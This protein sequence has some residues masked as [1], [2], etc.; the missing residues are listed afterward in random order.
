[1][2]DVNI[3]TFEEDGIPGMYV[4]HDDYAALEAERD[5]AVAECERLRADADR[6]RYYAPL[7]AERVGVNMQQFNAEIDAALAEVE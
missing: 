7:V 1:M 6:W 3:Y 2:S 5:A 4:D